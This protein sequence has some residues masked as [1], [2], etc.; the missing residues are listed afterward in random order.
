M[1]T[2]EF[3]QCSS[4]SK[5]RFTNSKSRPMA[6]LTPMLEPF[7]IHSHGEMGRELIAFVRVCLNTSRGGVWFG[8]KI[9]HL[10]SRIPQD[11]NEAHTIYS[12]FVD[13]QDKKGPSVYGDVN[14]VRDQSIPLGRTR[15]VS[16]GN[17][18]RPAMLDAPPWN[19]IQ[20]CKYSRKPAL[21]AR[22]PV[23]IQREQPTSQ[24]SER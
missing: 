20:T 11:I 4:K 3:A 21:A 15:P 16:F 10:I 17:G 19:L 24:K 6:W 22:G 1:Y 7:E 2:S 12:S 23:I 8:W 13:T 9:N 18:W 14:A 5:L